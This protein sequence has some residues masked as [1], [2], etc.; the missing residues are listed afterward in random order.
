[1]ASDILLLERGETMLVK[2]LCVLG[3]GGLICRF[4]M[5]S[6][7]LDRSLMQGVLLTEVDSYGGKRFVY[8]RQC[9]WPNSGR[10]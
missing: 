2:E 9:Y 4:V 8:V 3:G 5:H 6:C 7:F 1:M 10:N